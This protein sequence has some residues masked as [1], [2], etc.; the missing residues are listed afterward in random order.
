MG[1]SDFAVPALEHLSRAHDVVLAVVQPDKPSGRGNKITYLPVKK[2][3]LELGIPVAQPENISSADAEALL[4]KAGADVFVVCAYG[5]ILKQNILDIPPLGCLNIHGSVLPQYR[6]AAPVH[7]AV[8]DGRDTSG[9]TIMKL[10]AG[11]DTG[12]ILTKARVPVDDSTTTGALHDRLAEL[13]ADLLVRTLADY[14]QGRIQLQK[15]DESQASYAQKISKS[16]CQIDWSRP[17]HEILR[18]INGVD[19]FPAAHTDIDGVRVKIFS[20][21]CAQAQGS[22][23]APGT[24]LA[25]DAKNGLLVQCGDGVLKIKELQYPGKRRMNAED[26]FKGNTIPCTT[27]L[28]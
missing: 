6:G 27:V 21:E 11:M 15:Q 7:R 12:D 5:Q 4:K 25:A 28:K 1:S 24:V 20:P 14:E 3:A 10:D 18:L 23:Q 26:F 19:P 13:G 8:I 16:E 9:V 22:A 2:K 17:V